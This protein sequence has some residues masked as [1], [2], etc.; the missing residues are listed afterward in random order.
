MT[1]LKLRTIHQKH[2]R[3]NEKIS[4]GQ[5]NII[6]TRITDKSIYKSVVFI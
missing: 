2:L 1:T 6:M 4:A 3:N 5:G